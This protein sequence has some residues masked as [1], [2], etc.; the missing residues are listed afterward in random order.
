[1]IPLMGKEQLSLQTDFKH[2]ISLMSVW[3]VCSSRNSL[4]FGRSWTDKFHNPDNA[5]SYLIFS[6][7]ESQNMHKRTSEP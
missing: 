1:M 3:I 2:E 7:S 4:P 5:R 6:N